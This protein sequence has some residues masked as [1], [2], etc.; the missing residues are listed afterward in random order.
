[1]NHFR[2]TLR[3]LMHFNI[4]ATLAVAAWLVWASSAVAFELPSRDAPASLT[5][6]HVVRGCECPAVQ[7]NITVQHAG[8]EQQV[9]TTAT[10]ASR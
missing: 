8:S 1:M 2:L 3:A 5:H 7:A 10:V 6:A 4:G 9:G